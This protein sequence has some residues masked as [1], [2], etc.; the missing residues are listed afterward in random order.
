[1]C[2][3]SNIRKNQ[4]LGWAEEHLCR[5]KLL[6][7]ASLDDRAPIHGEKRLREMKKVLVL[8]LL[9]TLAR[10]FE[11]GG[12][13]R[14]RRAL[15]RLVEGQGAWP[16]AKRFSAYHL[17]RALELHYE[18]ITPKE[19][20]LWTDLSRFLVD[21]HNWIQGAEACEKKISVDPT[22]NEVLGLWPT[23]E[24]GQRVKLL[25][26]RCEQFQHAS[27]LYSYR[28]CLVHESREPNFS[29]ENDD[30]KEPLY[31]TVGNLNDR[32]CE[33]HLVYPLG[34]LISLATK[35]IQ[36]IGNNME[37]DPYSRF[38]YGCYIMPELNAREMA[39]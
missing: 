17:A 23:D 27:L 2:T 31:M 26:C 5:I 37:H 1:M 7:F 14:N 30:Y 15:V 35:C 22:E 4:F 39:P 24:R 21:K 25:K 32:R 29:Y 28:S 11:S 20:V 38:E 10:A 34:F 8:S 6:G 12:Q 16:D 19:R 3:E 13:G 9:E 36:N 33:Y 18:T